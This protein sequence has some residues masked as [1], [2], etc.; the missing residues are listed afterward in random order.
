MEK[1]KPLY[2][3]KIYPMMNIQILG[4]GIWEVYRNKGGLVSIYSAINPSK[5]RLNPLQNRLKYG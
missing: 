3:F 2:F 4:M 1:A 5:E